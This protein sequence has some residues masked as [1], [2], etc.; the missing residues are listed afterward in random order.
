[1]IFGEVRKRQRYFEQELS[2]RPLTLDSH[3][4]TLRQGAIPKHECLYGWLCQ[5]IRWHGRLVQNPRITAEPP[6]S[7]RRSNASGRAV[8]RLVGDSSG[9]VAEGD[10]PL[11]QLPVE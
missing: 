5:L 6:A 7:A 8:S 11:E 10:N 4:Q 9:F 3:P 2:A 1:M